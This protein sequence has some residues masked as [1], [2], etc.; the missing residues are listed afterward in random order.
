MKKLFSLFLAILMLLSMTAC[1]SSGDLDAAN[2]QITDLNGQINELKAQLEAA[3]GKAVVYA[4]QA[5]IDDKEFVTIDGE[6]S[7]AAKA[8][9]EEGQVVDHW[10]LNGQ[11]QE[12]ATDDTFTFTASESAIVEAV[13]RAEKKV[14]TV[15]CTIRLLDKDGDPAGDTYEEFSFE[16]PYTNPVTK[17]EITTGTASFQVKA[18]VPSGYTV[19][20][21]L[22]NGVKYDP[23]TTV[24]SFI[25]TDLDEATE[26]EAVLKEIY[27]KVTCSF[28]SVNGK[29]E[30]WVKAGSTVTVNA[31]S[32]FT[33]FF[34]LN[35]EKANSKMATS[36]TF[37]VKEN[38]LVEFAAV[39]N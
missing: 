34:Y 37:T 2:A 26:Y 38:T 39:I 20:Y 30:L 12:G 13:I 7:L 3:T 17:E 33:G 23:S 27:Y 5:T 6:K 22:I 24:H 36:Y 28:C 11:I 14:T 10:E 4:L 32:G 19:D 25:V 8:K 31:A 29:G 35:G 16:K 18:K 9:L 21:W 15:N 1:G